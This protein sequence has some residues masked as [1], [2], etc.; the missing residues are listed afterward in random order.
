[1]HD[2]KIVLSILGKIESSVLTSH[3]S[4]EVVSLVFV[5]LFV[6]VL[7]MADILISICFV[8]L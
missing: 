5:L 2:Y 8:P 3:R 7:Y 1:M 4:I 6:L